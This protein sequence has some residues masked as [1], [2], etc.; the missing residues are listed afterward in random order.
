VRRFYT[1]TH[2][3]AEDAENEAREWDIDTS[4]IVEA[5]RNGEWTVDGCEVEDAEVQ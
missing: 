5:V 2:N 4:D 1:G 3:S